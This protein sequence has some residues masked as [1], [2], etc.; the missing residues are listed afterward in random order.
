MQDRKDRRRTQGK[1]DFLRLMV[2][3]GEGREEDGAA[4]P[5]NQGQGVTRATSFSTWAWVPEGTRGRA[6]ET[7]LGGG[8]FRWLGE[9]QT[10]T[11]LF[12]QDGDQLIS[13]SNNASVRGEDSRL[14]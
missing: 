14:A 6:R 10:P 3:G 12:P 4:W 13:G 9:G 5:E 1:E 2:G 7:G 8:R 11:E